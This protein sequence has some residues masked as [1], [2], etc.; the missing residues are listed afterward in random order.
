MFLKKMFSFSTHEYFLTAH[1]TFVLVI[2]ILLSF[3]PLLYA[4]LK[5]PQL[6]PAGPLSVRRASLN[7]LVVIVFMTLCIGEIT[8]MGFNPFI[9]FK[10]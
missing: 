5:I 1:V 4:K 3:I 10:F 6:I 8:S 9:Y 2:A 7:A